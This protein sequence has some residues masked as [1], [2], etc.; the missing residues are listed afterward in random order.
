MKSNI[1]LPNLLVVLVLLPTLCFAQKLRLKEANRKYEDFQFRKALEF[2]HKVLEKDEDN[3]KA[4]TRIAKIHRILNHYE[5]SA[6]WYAKVIELEETKPKHFY[7][8]ANALRSTKN[9]D[10]AA[11]YY[12]AY[13][14]LA[15]YDERAIELAQG[16]KDSSRFFQDSIRY[17]VQK[18]SVNTHKPDFSPAFYKGDSIVFVSGRSKNKVNR[19]DVWSNAPFLDLYITDHQDNSSMARVFSNNLNSNYHE[20]PLAFTDSFKHVYFTRNN[21]DDK[22]MEDGVMDLN[23]LEAEYKEG[24]WTNIKS[25]AFNSSGSSAGHPTFTPDGD[26]MYFASDR[27]GTKGRLDIWRVVKDSAGWSEPENLGKDINTR[28][29]EHFPFYHPSGKLYFAS[30]GLPGLGGLDIY[31]AKKTSN[32]FTEPENMGFGVNSPMD[33]FGFIL[34]QDESKGFFSSNRQGGAGQSDIYSYTYEDVMEGFVYDKETE[35]PLTSTKV[36]LIQGDDTL[37]QK[38]VQNEDGEF[39]FDIEKDQNYRVTAN[40]KYYEPKT[41]EVSNKNSKPNVLTVNMPLEKLGD[42]NLSGKVVNNKTRD[43]I[44]MAKV[45]LFNRT[46]NDSATLFTGV[47]GNFN[48]PLLTNQEYNLQARKRGFFMSEPIQISTNNI[49]DETTIDT[50]IELDKL[51]EDAIVELENIY[52][53]LDKWNIRPEAET[54]LNKLVN[55]MKKYPEM[56][57]EMRSHTDSRGSK[58]YN[59]NLSRKRAKSTAKY[60]MSSGIT[61][62]RIKWKGFGEEQ[63]VNECSDGVECS[64]AKHQQ[65]RRTEFRVIDPPKESASASPSSSSMQKTKKKKDTAAYASAQF[66]EENMA[67]P[68]KSSES[69]DEDKQKNMNES[70][71]EGYYAVL[72]VFQEK[73]NAKAFKE[74][75]SESFD[76]DLY[77]DK[78][79]QYRVVTYLSKTRTSA[80]Q[81]SKDLRQQTNT[82]FWMMEHEK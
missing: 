57:V 56:T 82:N 62:D 21:L 43:P 79:G 6:K 44:S 30:N 42:I 77:L 33:D 39:L 40:K 2:Y 22:K 15:P 10:K 55:L 69:V 37:N 3:P 61:E 41:K 23:I 72:G 64:E 5:A 38:N 47:N 28:G 14:K 80:K 68:K 27:E 73:E 49:D 13:A 45:M 67:S 31:V 74:N 59:K 70:L 18:L 1:I 48:F 12:N 16:C 7:F 20:G 32:G 60:V 29:N 78:K 35:Q 17:S 4:I 11:K 54:V 51:I 81:K 58:A 66:M 9:Y 24:D 52:F 26:T 36:Y 50:T 19:K 75:K 63:L 25:L 34:N 53:D 8:Y 46:K 65:N 71:A 76:L